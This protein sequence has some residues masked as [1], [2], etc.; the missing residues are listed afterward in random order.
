MWL[1]TPQ[2]HRLGH[3]AGPGKLGESSRPSFWGGVPLRSSSCC[4]RTQIKDHVESRGVA[5][6]CVRRAACALVAIPASLSGKLVG[7][8]VT[9]AV[10]DWILTLSSDLTKQASP[11]SGGGQ[12]LEEGAEIYECFRLPDAA[13]VGSGAILRR[14]GMVLSLDFAAIW[15]GVL[16]LL[17]VDRSRASE[18]IQCESLR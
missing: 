14:F 17:F 6:G 9:P 7:T 3:G 15:S 5:T 16:L 12:N 2:L 11:K 4:S 1:H 10:S 18:E 13:W 8:D